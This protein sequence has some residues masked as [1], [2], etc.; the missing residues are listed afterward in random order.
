MG[1]SILANQ[2]RAN[3]W[4]NMEG[5]W[6]RVHMR[7]AGRRAAGTLPLRGHNYIEKRVARVRSLPK[8]KPF[9]TQ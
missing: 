9:I 2:R 6:G 4:G 3:V 5:Q 1:P 8:S 7:K